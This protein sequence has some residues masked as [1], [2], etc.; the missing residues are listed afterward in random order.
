MFEG[1]AQDSSE[2]TFVVRGPTILAFFPPTD[3]DTN[4]ALSDFQQYARQARAPLSKL[5][6]DFKEVYVGSFRVTSAGRTTR[7]RPG[8]T[9]V[10]YYFVLPGKKPR[11]EY[12]VMTD[13]DLI[14][15]AKDHFGLK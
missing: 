1:H 15:D 13:S 8:R 7:F 10:G 14:Q 9:K 5:G 4:E 2:P 3:P 6:V 11:V 12:G